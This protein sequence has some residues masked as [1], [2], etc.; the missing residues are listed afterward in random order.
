M[1]ITGRLPVVKGTRI[2]RLLDIPKFE[3]EVVFLRHPEQ[4][5]FLELI[6][7]RDPA[8]SSD[9]STSR[10]GFC[11][12]LTVPDLDCVHESLI[13]TGWRPFSEPLSMY[14]PAGKSVRLFCFRIDDGMLVELI[15]Q[16]S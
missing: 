11:L 1:E 6:C 9:S 16:V 2:S 5:V 14:D 15:E 3:A 4:K 13:E 8:V 12:T 7:Q 10:S